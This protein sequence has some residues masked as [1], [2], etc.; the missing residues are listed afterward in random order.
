MPSYTL[1]S[2][3]LS[4]GLPAAEGQ[5]TMSAGRARWFHASALLLSSTPG[6]SMP[7]AQAAS[8]RWS[9][10]VAA[11]GLGGACA[12]RDGGGQEGEEY[13]PNASMESDEG[14]ADG[15]DG[16]DG[17][18]GD[19]GGEDADGGDLDGLDHW[20]GWLSHVRG[21]GYTAGVI[22]CSLVWTTEGERVDGAECP[23]CA[24]V[25]E[26]EETLDRS[27]S[28]GEDRC[29]DEAVDYTR[30]LGYAPDYMG[31]GPALVAVDDAY[32]GTYLLGFA[33]LDGD[34]LSWSYGYI[35]YAFVYSDRTYY[36]TWH[37][38]GEAELSD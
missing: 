6:C 27:A 15:A 10:V 13:D 1:C 9:L 14:G 29:A 5:G 8:V 18:G 16:A 26:V 37:W 31:Y 20:E 2:P 4:V 22:E 33:R 11:L 24:F 35:D 25:F 38:E 30:K 28:E 17:G 36:S 32:W 3:A 34:E 7:S 19:D 12:Q 21:G 23:D